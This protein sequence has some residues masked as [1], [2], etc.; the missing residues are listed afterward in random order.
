[1][2]K[3]IATLTILGTMSYGA[4]L[5]L[6]KAYEASLEYESKIKS[7]YYQVKSKQEDITQVKAKLYPQIHSSASYVRRKAELNRTKL[8]EREN[9]QKYSIN[10]SQVIYHPEIYTQVES[11]RLKYDLTNLSYIQQKHDLA[12]NVTDAYVSILKAQN[13]IKVAKSFMDSTYAKH[14]QIQKKFN[15]RL[16]NK[17]DYLESKVIYEQAKIDLHKEKNLLILAKLR[18]KNLIGI[19]LEDFKSVD[20]D[21]INI[22]RLNLDQFTTIDEN[23]EV[24]R[25]KVGVQLSKKEITLAKYGHYPKVDLTTSYSNYNSN[26]VI[27]DYENDRTI[28]LELKMPIFQGGLISSQVQKNRLI[29]KS[30]NADLNNAK[31]EAQIKYEELKVNY[32]LAFDNVALYKQSKE[33]AKLYLLAVNKGYDKGLKDLIELEDAKT[34]YTRTKFELI[35][36]IY[37]L[38]NSYIGILNITG[39]MNVKYLELID[40]VLGIKE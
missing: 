9:Y 15:L 37:E 30:A 26:N 19:N 33:S 20:F 24:Q 21:N 31:R 14:K 11:S 34:K 27:N 8:D 4:N 39:N 40:S 1:M 7:T 16:A 13:S 2:K 6:S 10:A 23:L 17:M 5:S 28:T 36:S 38:I 12:Y 22:S 29:L 3:M 18:L 32:D 35:Q 25:A